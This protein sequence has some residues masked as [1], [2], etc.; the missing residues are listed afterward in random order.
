MT[1]NHDNFTS[2]K[3]LTNTKPYS[4]QISWNLKPHRPL[5]S[6]LDKNEIQETDLRN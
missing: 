6:Q 3:C 4:R 2:R 5:N 1:D